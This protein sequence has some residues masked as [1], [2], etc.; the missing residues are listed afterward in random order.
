[1]HVVTM[2]LQGKPEKCLEIAQSLQGIA[3]KLKKLEGC[4]DSQVYQAFD[5]EYTFFFVE[6]WQKQRALDDH[7]KSSLFAAL[8]GIKELLTR[9]LEI[10]FMVEN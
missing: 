1:M 4:I 6:E 8:L 5:D 7:M 9:P 10:K 3:N 2:K